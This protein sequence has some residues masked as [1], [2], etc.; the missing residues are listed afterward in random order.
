[1]SIML[2]I[3]VG[4]TR[5]RVG[6]L[7]GT[8]C[9][10]AQS[11]A[12]DAPG[13]IAA[14]ASALFDEFEFDSTEP[15]ILMSTVS[16]S[17]GDAIE[18]ILQ[19][20]FGWSVY[21]LGRD[22]PIPIQHTLTPSGEETVGQDRLLC[23]LGAYEAVKQACVVVDMGTAITV[24]F[25]D[26]EGVFHGGAIL[27]GVSMMLDSLHQQTA[28]LPE[29]KFKKIDP[30]SNEP[31]KDTPDAMILGVTAGAS[32]AIRYLTERYAQFYEGYPQIIATGGDIGLLEDDELI[33]AFVPDLQLHGI[34][35]ACQRVLA[36]EDDDLDDD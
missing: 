22:I 33:E 5:T 13:E 29:L 4:N 10:K 18:E 11:V 28:S 32:G 12:T 36:D 26:G 27:P 30:K 23:A 35:I 14:F 17:A 24:D 34:R 2:V 25:V 6:I 3:A 1:M 15:L 21:R 20:R 9:V 19:S 31:G 16:A 8:E 7:K